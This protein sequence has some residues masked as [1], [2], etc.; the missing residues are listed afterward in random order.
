MT[1]ILGKF[2]I[3]TDSTNIS[4]W[5]SAILIECSLQHSISPINPFLWEERYLL[6]IGPPPI[7]C[8]NLVDSKVIWCADSKYNTQCWHKWFFYL[9]GL[10]Y[11]RFQLRG[12]QLFGDIFQT[13]WW[14]STIFW[15]DGFQTTTY[16]FVIYTY[17]KKSKFKG[18]AID[19]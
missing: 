2:L 6:R 3:S 14:I 18:L 17:Y 19:P 13:V 10:G 15:H 5:I 1:V 16:F 12:T 7:W 11:C 4:K 9:L 8:I